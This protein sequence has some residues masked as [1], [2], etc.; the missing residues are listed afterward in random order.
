MKIRRD[1]IL[2]PEGKYPNP[3]NGKGY[4]QFYLNVAKHS[5][6]EYQTYLDRN[7]IFKKLYYNSII[8]V[9]AGTGVG[10]TVILPKLLAHYFGYKTPIL[11][12]TPR[13][14]TTESAADWA[15]KCMDVPLFYYKMEG[16]FAMNVLD[17]SGNPIRTGNA[18]IG[19]K[20]GGTDPI[21]DPRKTKLLYCTDSTVKQ[22]I[23]Q[24][25]E[26]LAR[27]GGLV[28]D[29]AHERSVSIDILIALVVEIVKKRSDFKVIIM[30]AT[31]NEQVFVDYFK[32]SG[33]ENVFTIY[34]ASVPGQAVI[35][36]V[37]LEKKIKANDY[38][39][40]AIEVVEGIIKNPKMVPI[41]K[42]GELGLGDILV[43]VSSAPEGNMIRQHILKNMD[44]Y[45]QDAKPYPVILTAKSKDSE[46]EIATG[47][48]GVTK[49]PPEEGVFHRKLIIA[50]NVAESS[51]TFE[52]PLVYVV[53]TGVEFKS[54][55]DA[56]KYANTGGIDFIA[57]ANM[58]QRCG[59]TGRTCPGFC[60]KIY[61]EEQYDKEIEDYPPPK[62]TVTDLT[63]EY[64][65]ILCLSEYRS[66]AKTSHFLAKMIQPFEDIKLQVDVAIRN[67]YQL[68]IISDTGK[69][70]SL[71]LV[72][73]KF[74][75]FDYQVAKMIIGGYYF[76]CMPECIALGAI[77]S[78]LPSIDK[79]F[80]K[81]PDPTDKGQQEE[82]KKKM[83]KFYHDSG[84]HITALNFFMQWLYI[85]DNYQKEEFEKEYDLNHD[86]MKMI[87]MHYDEIIERVVEIK[88]LIPKLNLFKTKIDKLFGGGR[89]LK[90]NNSNLN[91][92]PIKSYIKGYN[93]L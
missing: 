77:L 31:V 61:T 12:A 47:K 28:I 54:Y 75:K 17:R 10:K 74:G 69:L 80:N 2:D 81:L 26:L 21:Y 25:D 3:F 46:K 49:V 29:E 11:V 57:K 67:L 8:L 39:P 73:N 50:T 64:L 33:L 13:Q 41:N 45:P 6:S 87:K 88:D 35:E 32:R 9:I 42:D 72:L 20:H 19:M 37:W 7:E 55:Y 52:D 65:S 86:S 91:K 48:N 22:M 16:K 92:S 70:R 36:P 79:M 1:G 90:Y 56:G 62:I 85:Y 4:S 5:W 18:Y 78:S 60:Y 34:E 44:Q 40:K 59:R 58:K 63:D 30:S 27:Y 15:A 43:F 51:I 68:G 93:E 24:G 23:I 71:G 84:D 76:G 53:E 82:L 38:I 66:V 83:M 89:K 14:K